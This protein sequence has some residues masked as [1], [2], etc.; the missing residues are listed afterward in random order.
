[1]SEK[2]FLEEVEKEKKELAESYEE[3]V[4]QNKERT[5]KSLKTLPKLKQDI[6]KS[7]TQ[8]SLNKKYGDLV[9]NIITRKLSE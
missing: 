8:N 5:S 2:D 3:S 9:E 7:V 6:V 1:M 4:R